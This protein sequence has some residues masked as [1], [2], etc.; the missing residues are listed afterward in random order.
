MQGMNVICWEHILVYFMDQFNHNFI[1]DLQ[2]MSA[3][4]IV[5]QHIL[6]P[7]KQLFEVNRNLFYQRK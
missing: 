1:F 2:A 4:I 5:N 3:Y 6:V 7:S